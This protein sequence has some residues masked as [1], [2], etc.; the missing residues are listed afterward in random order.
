MIGNELESSSRDVSKSVEKV[1]IEKTSVGH[2]NKQRDDER[3][4][5]EDVEKRGLAGTPQVVYC[6][7]WQGRQAIGKR[8]QAPH[9]AQVDLVRRPSRHAQ[10][11]L[12]ARVDSDRRHRQVNECLKVIRVLDEVQV[13]GDHWWHTQLNC[14]AFW[15]VEVFFVVVDFEHFAQFLVFAFSNSIFN[16]IF[17]K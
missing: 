9:Q 12:S 4:S 1:K 13:V 16:W 17:I 7:A 2:L 5:C 3:E 6:D 15:D 11:E 8:H 14:A 10:I